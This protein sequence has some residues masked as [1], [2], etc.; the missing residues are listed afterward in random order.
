MARIHQLENALIRLISGPVTVA[1]RRRKNDWIAVALQFDLAGIGK[2]KK[3]ALGELRE[4]IN[5]Y[6]GAILKAKGP[7]RV[8]NPSEQEEWDLP[9][10]EHYYVSVM[11][12]G[13]IANEP[14]EI[15][16]I[17]SLKPYAN[18]IAKFDL[19]RVPA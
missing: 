4:C 8:F 12:S 15:P 13:P 17:L 1:Y 7:V 19:T 9:D 3:E 2:T 18:R 11:I 6:L 10:Q 16:N 5:L 14:K